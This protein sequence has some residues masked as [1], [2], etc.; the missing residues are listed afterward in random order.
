[1][2]LKKFVQES[3][4]KTSYVHVLSDST[5]VP[6]HFPNE[7]KEA[8]FGYHFPIIW[9]DETKKVWSL[10][11]AGLGLLGNIPGDEK[12]CA[13]IEDTAVSVADLPQYIAEFN[14]ILQQKYGIECE[15]SANSFCF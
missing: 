5:N 9:G 15:G 8:G 6:D 2:Q 13:V 10:R 7:L 4:Q 12:P 3:S 1:M 14:Q 11:V